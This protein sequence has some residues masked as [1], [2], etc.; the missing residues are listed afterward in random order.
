MKRVSVIVALLAVLCGARAQGPDDQYIQI[1]NLIQEADAFSNTDQPSRALTRYLEAQA[2]LQKL[3]KVYPDWNTRVVSF[4]MNYLAGRV[5]AMQAR[6]PP[7]EAPAV[8]ARPGAGTKTGAAQPGQP[9]PPPDWEGQ[10]R[11]LEDQLRRLQ[12]DRVSL[13]AK[14]KEALAAQPARSDPREL[15]RAEDKIRELAKENNLLNVALEQEKARVAPAPDTK[16]LEQAQQA[17]AQARRSLAEET[18]KAEALEKE[19]TALQVKLHN[20]SPSSWNAATIESTRKAL[21]A[22]NRQVAEQTKLA[23]QL[24]KE[25]ETLAARLKVLKE[26]SDAAAA[27]REENQL[28][29][30]QLAD[31]KAAKPAAAGSGNAQRDLA[32]AQAQIAMLKSDKEILRLEKL[33]LENR[34]QQLS[35]AAQRATVAAS[36]P[37]KPQDATRIKQLERERDD[38]KQQL[39]ASAKGLKIAQAAAATAPLTAKPEDSSRIKK[40]ERERDDLKQ[41]LDASARELKSARTAASAA[42][43]L[44]AKPGDAERIKKLQQE[45]DE[46]KQQLELATKALNDR[47]SKTAAAHLVE[48]Q[49]QVAVLRS[50][51]DVFEARQVPYTPEEL[52]LFRQS[53]PK[54]VPADTR[55]SSKSAR[56]LPPGT[57]ALAAEAQRYFSAKQ[58]DKAEDRYMQVLRQAQNNVPTLA[59]LAAV[60]LELNHLALAE[61]NILQAI[62]LAPDN[63]ACLLTLGHLRFRQGQYD[64]ALDALSRA[65]KFDPESAEIQNYLGLTLSAKGLRGPAETALRRAVQLD[66]R[67]GEAHNNL[68]VIYATQQPALVELAR[69]HYQK[70]LAAGSPP[71][72]ELEKLLSAKKAAEQPQQ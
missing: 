16:A 66:L 28:L 65:A 67:Y 48:M 45:R 52:A 55:V 12:E 59:N 18:R 38:L 37:A 49:N 60:E 24:A 62:A 36:P 14:L 4:R 69:W 25:K 41:Q 6:V 43:P 34:V 19:K 21:D 63:P 17:L 39:E 15:S 71:N 7:V 42:P 40:L 47:K 27:L 5:A 13:E 32:R 26:E 56:E 35:S 3:Q 20:L 58:L 11:A 68:A 2:L 50:R 10:R 44:A 31:L 54:P 57:V 33:A 22:A 8:T 30:K 23:S 1:Y 61:T 51:L 46:L 53:E 29:K 64:A 70:A 72:P 9:A